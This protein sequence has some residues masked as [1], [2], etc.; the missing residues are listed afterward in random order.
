MPHVVLRGTSY[1][2]LSHPSFSFVW[3]VRALIC[4]TQTTW[5]NSTTPPPPKFISLS[6][7]GPS[8]PSADVITRRKAAVDVFQALVD[9]ET[10][11]QLHTRCPQ[12]RELRGDHYRSDLVY[13]A[14]ESAF[15]RPS[16]RPPSLSLPFRVDRVATDWTSGRW[17]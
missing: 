5:T 16:P 6:L 1:F 3:G 11:S 9:E 4:I 17:E 8:Y 10:S 15:V 7:P 13:R 12:L 2:S 14:R